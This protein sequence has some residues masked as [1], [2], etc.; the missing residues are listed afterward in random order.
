[1]NVHSHPPATPSQRALVTFGVVSRIRLFSRSVSVADGIAV[2]MI[3]A[4]LSLALSMGES[5]SSAAT[6][7]L[8][9]A[10]LMSLLLGR[11]VLS[12]AQV[13]LP[14]DA[15]APAEIVLGFGI[16]SA[17]MLCVGIIGGV[18]A[19]T[20]LMICCAIGLAC[21]VSFWRPQ[22]LHQAWTATALGQLLFICC[23]SFV[24]SWD[25]IHTM[26]R[27][28]TAGVFTSWIDFFVHAGLV[29]QFAHLSEIGGTSLFVA[30]EPIGIYHFGSYMLP[31]A[32]KAFSG[33]SAMVVV[34][35]LWGLLGCILLGIGAI[36]IGTVL[37]G[38]TGGVAA[39][40][41]VL[42]VP[43]AGH[44]GFENTFF[45]YYW[46][47]QVFCGSTYGL[48]LA[49]LALA[50]GVLAL[51]GHHGAWTLAIITGALVAVF[52]IHIFVLLALSAILIVVLYWRPDRAWLRPVF[53]ASLL[54]VGIVA[55]LVAERIPRAPH[56]LSGSYDPLAMV[57]SLTTFSPSSLAVLKQLAALSMPPLV[58]LIAAVL[59]VL[60]SAFGAVLLGYLVVMAVRRRKLRPE[61][62][63]PLGILVAYVVML[64]AFPVDDRRE[65]QHR[66]FWCCV[67]IARTAR[68]WLT[69][70]NALI[71]A[72]VVG[73]LLV[74]Y[75]VTRLGRVQG[76]GNTWAL[77]LPS[78]NVDVAE[79]LR[80]SAEYIRLHAGMADVVWSD[81]DD[82][83][84]INPA[85]TERSAFSSIESFAASQPGRLR[86][87]ILARRDVSQALHASTHSMAQFIATAK[88]AG[89]DWCLLSPALHLPDSFAD[90]VVFSAGG[91]RVLR[92]NAASKSAR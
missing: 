62:L 77:E 39:V 80:Q 89:I 37:A 6:L 19:G 63:V 83:W 46:A 59:V 66:P 9:I 52:R 86:D 90:R 21:C 75:P 49:L 34:T 44:Y 26:P 53:F 22:R 64:C 41:A 84:A 28:L 23:L 27:L 5:V 32:V 38:R 55:A 70:R 15:V 1:M 60:V 50:F 25:A 8:A 91:I 78:V 2:L 45:D 42:L 17:A 4:T 16:L 12:R 82:R 92:V 31:A 29:T 88:A 43:S 68:D 56:F 10:M 24:W 69:Q 33:Q 71:A 3:A 20:S 51:R 47:L 11:T 48:G 13:S 40:V 65:F 79:G 81:N 76:A 61:D 72:S 58:V 74:A 7:V 85:L 14:D 18:G 54:P 73:T 36:V 57:A 87:Q 30:G 67:F 35:T